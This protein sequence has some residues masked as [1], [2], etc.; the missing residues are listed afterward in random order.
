M[1]KSETTSTFDQGL[2]MD[3]NPIV[4]PNNVLSNALNATLITMNGNENALQNDMGNG[5]VE[6]AYLPEGYIPLGTTELGGI[7]YIVSYNPF[8]GTCQIGS[9]PSPERN[10]TQ[11]EIGNPVQLDSSK[12]YKTTDEEI[13]LISTPSQI[14]ILSDKIL[15][16]GDK[17][18]VQFN[19]D[20]IQGNNNDTS[21]LSAYNQIN[22]N[23]NLDPKYIK[24]DIVAIQENGTINKL[25]NSLTWGDYYY[26]YP[27]SD[28]T[29]EEYTNLIK[30]N[31][32]VFQSKISGNLGILATLECISNFDVSWDAIKNGNNWDFYFY[33][34]WEY[35]GLE[36]SKVNPSSCYIQCSNEQSGKKYDLLLPYMNG[37]ENDVSICDRGKSDI[38]FYNPNI[39]NSVYDYEQ[40]N[41]DYSIIGNT[42][43]LRKND[44]TD[45]QFV[46]KGPSISADSDIISFDI[47]PGMPFGFLDYLKQS[48]T[49]DIS[50]LGTGEINLIQYQYYVNENSINVKWGLEVY[51]EKNKNVELV[52]FNLYPYE[53][54]GQFEIN[55]IDSKFIKQNDSKSI[56]VSSYND[57]DGDT[58][59][60][61]PDKPNNQD[62]IYQ[63]QK[64]SYSGYDSFT[65]NQG[66]DYNKLYLVEINV[67]YTDATYRFYRLMYTNGIFN[68]YFNVEQDFKN[69]IL[70]DAINKYSQI[71]YHTTNFQE[72]NATSVQNIETIDGLATSSPDS[73][74]RERNDYPIQYNTSDIYNSQVSFSVKADCNKFNVKLS[75]FQNPQNTTSIENNSNPTMIVETGKPE[76][77]QNRD[78]Q[79]EISIQDRNN[80][81]SQYFNQ[82]IY[83]SNIEIKTKTPFDVI[84]N[85]EDNLSINYEFSPIS[86]V[87]LKLMTYMTRKDRN[88]L[89]LETSGGD[90][91]GEEYNGDD[92]NTFNSFSNWNNIASALRN[93]LQSYDAAIIEVSDQSSGGEKDQQ[94]SVGMGPIIG[95][96]ESTKFQINMRCKNDVGSRDTSR[97]GTIILYAFLS[98][99]GEL[100]IISPSRKL[101]SIDSQT[102]AL[103]YENWYGYGGADDGD[104]TKGEAHPYDDDIYEIIKSGIKVPFFT[105]TTNNQLSAD[106]KSMELSK[107]FRYH[108][109]VGQLTVAYY[110]IIKYY[111]LYTSILTITVSGTCT[112]ILQLGGIDIISNNNIKNLTYSFSNYSIQYQISQKIDQ[113]KYVNNIINDSSSSYQYVK[114]TYPKYV[115]TV[116]EGTYNGDLK[117]LRYSVKKQTYDVYEKRLV[118]TNSIFDRN[119]NQLTFLRKDNG[120]PEEYTVNGNEE[121]NQIGYQ[122]TDWPINIVDSTMRIGIGDLEQYQGKV[123]SP[124]TN[125]SYNLAKWG[126]MQQ[127]EEQTLGTASE[128][129]YIL[130]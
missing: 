58:P 6:T 94:M 80:Q 71:S 64:T 105:L 122:N 67:K 118:S 83:T 48:I 82:D 50:K 111:K 47:L 65:I 23:P 27:H 62:N 76:T 109:Y 15:N 21:Q 113:T 72:L 17:F 90:I 123:N 57:T 74:I 31:Y 40:N 19:G 60:Y 86:I 2:V 43:A 52:T 85:R 101:N 61:I 99:V 91:L 25:T 84:Y 28:T 108:N 5:K 119:G 36:A 44:G 97:K 12:F 126:Y 93:Q 20:S 95:N 8:R 114:C 56:W 32:S 24:L 129:F 127:Y 128:S 89:R 18:I 68:N 45:N 106:F 103:I 96:D 1:K 66:V 51:P 3:I 53:D 46:I 13:P 10:L 70:Q 11:D 110:N 88:Y 104:I 81:Q 38:E 9:F 35:T 4:T 124:L 92:D 117:N 16:P 102:R 125:F 112:Q 69:I 14:I 130:L 49:V 73:F 37:N 54:I 75:N 107:Y 100:I 22:N 121:E 115:I 120:I 41:T 59:I 34:N 78:I 39:L 26:I 63:I 30:S 87:H 33:L 116:K 77:I 98:E 42:G 29:I 55:N 79:Y 7:I